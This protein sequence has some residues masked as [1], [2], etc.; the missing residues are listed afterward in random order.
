[1]PGVVSVTCG[2][3]LSTLLPA[4]GPAVTQLPATSQIARE[5]VD[6]LALSVPV[7]TFVESEKL[8]SA[9]LASPE[10]PS[11]DV[12]ARLTS[13]ACHIP[14]ASAQLTLGTIWSSEMVTLPVVQF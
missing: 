8:A 7:A 5:P 6:A 13:L 4:I 9:P 11:L 2:G 12:H 14:S 3:F 10:S 1:M